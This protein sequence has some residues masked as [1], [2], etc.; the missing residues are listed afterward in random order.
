MERC[1]NLGDRVYQQDSSQQV[2]NDLSLLIDCP[3]WTHE[4]KLN[5]IAWH[6][7]RSAMMHARDRR[8]N[9]SI[10]LYRFLSDLGDRVE[11]WEH[12]PDGHIV[13]IDYM[14]SP[15]LE[16]TLYTALEGVERLSP[17]KDSI[18]FYRQKHHDHA[19]RVHK[20]TRPQ[21][22]RFMNKLIASG[23]I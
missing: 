23:G 17:T 14:A 5:A 8:G 16:L 13:W 18:A 6:A 4:D 2:I 11:R 15:T 21:W 1:A 3:G 9:R 19:L 12:D 20:Y 7:E 22:L 10:L